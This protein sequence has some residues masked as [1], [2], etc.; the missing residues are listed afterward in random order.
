[1]QARGGLVG[2]FRGA[3][4]VTRA[5]AAPA[6][7]AAIVGHLARGGFAPGAPSAAE[8][9]LLA[10]AATGLAL[11]YRRPAATLP[12]G[13][14]RPLDVATG[15]VALAVTAALVAL[16]G[17]VTG[18]LG[19]AP[20]LVIAA[21]VALTS[22]GLGWT[23]LAALATEAALHLG[24][25]GPTRWTHLAVRVALV[26][27]AA[28]LHHGLTRVEV[29][30]IRARAGR[31][32]ADEKRRQHEAAASFR[33]VGG[34][35]TEGVKADDATRVR[36]SLEE[37]HAAL[38]GLLT[39]ARRTLS[40][41]TCA[42]FWIDAR[43]RTMRLVEAATDDADLVTEPI[44]TGAGALGAVVA[45]G[46]PVVLSNLKPAYPGL[47]YY[48]GPHGVRAFA[49]IPVRDGEA[50]RGIL[51]ADRADADVFPEEALATLEMVAVQARRLIDNE[52]VFAR[53]DRARRELSTL[54]DAARALGESLTEAE[55]LDAVVRSV[56]SVLDHDLLVVTGYDARTHTHRVRVAQGDCGGLTEGA[57]FTDN[58]GLVSA[59]LKARHALP[60]RGQFDPKTQ[61]VF[62]RAHPLKGMQSVLILP[63]VTGDRVLGA[64]TVGAQRAGAF[65]ES[66]RQLLGVLAAHAAVAM[67]N[68]AAVSHLEEM[69]TTDPMTGHLNKRALETE[70]DRRLRAAER[71]DRPLA[72][73]VLDIDKFKS[74]N[75]TYGHST[76]DVVIKGL[77]AVLTRCRRDT[78]AVGR[79]GGEEFVVLCEE[80]DAAGAFQLAE[81][82]REE[83]KAQRFTTE[84]GPLQ[85]TCSLGIAAFP[86]DGATRHDLFSRADEALYAAKHGGR[87]QTRSASP[88]DAP[89]RSARPRRSTK[90]P[91]AA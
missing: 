39:L 4:R 7:V 6:S 43:G 59:A 70:F 71:F 9:A 24:A 65:G 1:M 40:L 82:I 51:V 11:R 8:M 85:V 67:A 84:H 34:A 26:G 56:G 91:Q 31:M 35:P 44:D 18:P 28:A 72:V 54:F 36:A 69:A 57:T 41:R 16:A 62:T 89:A 50:V 53:L 46:R 20:L 10:F 88:L 2:V 86:H 77:G 14:R 73:I 3:L 22:R 23:L 76:G 83:L 60:Y 13:A 75:D 78:D 42:L 33:I 48:R 25:F 12:E 15:P 47:P 37:I 87:N 19:A 64:L 29:A 58:T 30:R 52:R 27:A 81:R 63:L 66:T 5:V 74:V 79:F 90:R 61:V 49:G 38:V 55:V 32:L 68:A 21:A 45:M 80:T 17:G